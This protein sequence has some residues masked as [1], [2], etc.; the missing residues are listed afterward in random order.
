MAKV[1][2]NLFYDSVKD[3]IDDVSKPPEGGFKLEY[4][5]DK[6]HDL[7]TSRAGSFHG[8]WLLYYEF[9]SN[10]RGNYRNS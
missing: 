2:R 5:Q 1:M 7:E 10:T 9:R 3:F 4:H 6:W 8:S